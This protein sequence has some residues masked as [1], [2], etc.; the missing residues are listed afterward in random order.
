MLCCTLSSLIVCVIT[1]IVL[2]GVEVEYG[3]RLF[4]A[5]DPDPIFQDI[6]DSAFE[7]GQVTENFKPT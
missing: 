5:V 4:G 1:R 6:S 7:I 2:L 3:I